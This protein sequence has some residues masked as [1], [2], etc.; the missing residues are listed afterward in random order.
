M[1]KNALLWEVRDKNQDYPSYV[2]GTMHL[3]QQSHAE[4]LTILES[5]MEDVTMV[6]TE[7]SLSNPPAEWVYQ[8]PDNQTLKDL[9]GE[10]KYQKSRRILLKALDFDLDN[11]IS[12]LPLIITQQITL[13]IMG[14]EKQPSLDALIYQMVLRNN[15]EY[16][17]IESISEQMDIM[18]KI[19]LDY[20]INSLVHLTRNIST[21]R[22]KLIH[23]TI[24][25]Q[26]QRISELYKSS[27]KEM[28]GIRKILLY[29]RNVIIADRIALFHQ[30]KASL[31]TFGAGHLAGFM[32]VL[33]LLKR[34]GIKVRAVL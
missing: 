24:L 3:F 8:L 30:E 11:Y 31:F 22:K 34:K 14:A 25:F 4:F 9:I 15:K 33:S 1:L 17:G 23:L 20:Q 2:F 5:I 28:G 19:P 6:F 16:S 21:F 29:D 26:K 18:S 12:F 27:K 10:R 32:G 7:V 13:K